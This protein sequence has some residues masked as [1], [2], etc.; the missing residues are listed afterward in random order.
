MAKPKGPHL[1]LVRR[2]TPP[3]RAGSE[4]FEWFWELVGPHGELRQRSAWGW[5]RKDHALARIREVARRCQLEA[6]A[7]PRREPEGKLELLTQ[8]QPGQD[9]P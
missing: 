1:R 2:P 3:T 8:D 4:P 5:V 9:K 7:P 6:W